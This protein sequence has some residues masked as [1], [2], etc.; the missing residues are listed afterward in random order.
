MSMYNS[1]TMYNS[2]TIS[3]STPKYNSRTMFGSSTKY[4]SSAN[5]AQRAGWSSVGN[6]SAEWKSSEIIGN[7]WTLLR[8]TISFQHEGLM[9][10]NRVDPSRTFLF[11]LL[12][13]ERIGTHLILGHLDS[14][15]PQSSCWM[16]KGQFN[17]EDTDTETQANLN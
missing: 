17:L 16:I 12:W 15:A 6:Q 11:F 3:N 4:G 2:S 14:Q 10:C 1:T 7:Y 9:P 13:S 8:A 5:S